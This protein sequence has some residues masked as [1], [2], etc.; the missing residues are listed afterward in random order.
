MAEAPEQP[1]S[2][3]QARRP[4]SLVPVG[5]KEAALD[6]PTFRATALH[7]SEHVD[8]VE[9]WLDAYVRS[10]TKLSHEVSTV[11]NLLNG[12]L[13][14]M[15]PPPNLS[16]AVIDHDY[17]LLAVKRYGEGAK[18]FWGSTI[19]G[20]RKLETNM[21]DPVRNFLQTDLRAFKETRRLLDQSQKQLDS[22]QSRYSAQAKTKEPS[23]LREDAFQLHEA[24]K[25]Y[26]KACMDFCVTTP[27]FRLALDKMLVKVSSDQW[28]DMR[29]A[30]ENANMALSRTS[31]DLDRIRGWS[32]EM[33]NGERTFKRE[34][35][36][37]RKQIEE[38][39]ESLVRPSR[40]LEDYATTSKGPS[41]SLSSAKPKAIQ[42]EKQGWL[43][44]RTVTGKPARTS[45]LR[46]WFFVKNGI[47]G[48]LV[49]G[50]RSGGV[51]ESDRI[52]VLLCSV[53]L[54][55]QEERRFC[56]EVKTKDTS[57][58][59]QAESQP[60]L[61]EWMAVFDVA[62]KKALEDPASTDSPSIGSSQPMDPAFAISPPSAPE[63]A[64]SA[65]DA[66]I[67]HT[68]DEHSGT[69]FDRST[70]LPIPGVEHNASRGSFDFTNQ[71]RSTTVDR[72]GESSREPTGRLMSKLDLHRKST[73]SSQSG[74]ES[75]GVISPKSPTTAVGGIA[76]LIAA[77]HSAMPVGPAVPMPVLENQV[78]QRSTSLNLRNLPP[79]S[80]APSTFAAP[81]TP[82]NL[83]ATA[84]AVNRERGIGVG[85]G[86]MT[87]GMPSGIMA[88]LWG[89]SNWGYMNRLERGEVKPVQD[90]RRSLFPPS[91]SLPA[92][93][94]PKTAGLNGNGSPQER[95]TTRD[96]SPSHRKTI[97]L[98]GDVADLQRNLIASQE[99]P[100]SYPL[101]LRAQDA[102]FRL[103]FPNVKRQEKVVTVFRATWNP[104]DQQEFP[105]RVYVTASDIYF[106]S[107][108]LGLVLITG[109]SLKSIS[110]VTAAPGRDCDFLF[111]HL[112]GNVD[113]MNY[114]RI[115]IKTFL[116]P[117]KLLQ[118]RLNFLVQNANAEEPL[119]LEEIIKNLIRLESDD[120]TRSPSLESW[121]DFSNNSMQRSS[122]MQQNG[123]QKTARDLRA[124]VLVD[125]AFYGVDT[126]GDHSKENRIKLPPQPVVYAPRDMKVCAVEKVF[127]ISPKAL[128]H[129]MFGDRSAVWQLLYHE[130]RAQRIKQGPWIQEEGTHMRRTF[131]YRIEY[132]DLFRARKEAGI[133]DH[134]MIDVLNDHLLYVVTDRKT[135]WHLP[136]AND[137]MLVSKVVITHVAK[138]KCK[139]AVYTKIDWSRLPRIGR[140]MIEQQ[141][142]ADLKLDAEDLADVISDQ[143]RKLGTQSRTKK[144]I[145]IFGYI[146][147]QKQMIE[148]GENSTNV[149][150][151]TRRTL[152]RR[153]I[154][155]LVLESVSS[156]IESMITSVLQWIGDFLR[157]T[158]KILSA[159]RVILIVLL[160]SLLTNLFFSWSGT[161]VWWME[162]NARSYMQKL[163]VGPDLVMSKAVHLD[164]LDLATSLNSTFFDGSSNACVRT[165]HDLT[166]PSN[167]SSAI[168]STHSTYTSRR[169]RR[170]RQH[171]GTYRY[172]LLVAMR[173][174]NS[175][176]QE[177]IQ[178]EWEEWTR[179]EN[180]RCARMR[181]LLK[182]K[183]D[184]KASVNREVSGTALG[185]VDR[186]RFNEYCRSCRAAV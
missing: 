108:H 159:N 7:F 28:R 101:Q 186:E 152:G 114:T 102:Q 86:D 65:A 38:Q 153:T 166:S 33:E 32:R 91:P 104:N 127:N 151:H 47:F 75:S 22:L 179:A 12:F 9:K 136:Y 44:L 85:R 125:R 76:S 148:F 115:T 157:W 113:Q 51:E 52:G 41:V 139:L 149:D 123:V 175:I 18:E 158:W 132:L 72:D 120:A 109:I 57:V 96:S 16:E 145:Q 112:N 49:Q 155:G 172:D 110:E 54:A 6:S 81:P 134:Q 62:K 80:L 70:T 121:E 11:E 5:L 42:S 61:L 30:R 46:R 118:R 45:W 116:E 34:L 40:E 138:S 107:N 105:G 20:L 183:E 87:G 180:R 68:T 147:Q 66:G 142:M 131:E 164:D 43:N 89:S 39:A 21:V 98:D 100:S 23:A 60:E 90:T 24:R 129:V 99:F 170:T 143:V 181:E 168:P 26:L 4:V 141:A 1:P 128:F 58:I 31:T 48:W 78:Q 95:Q 17:T 126:K 106:Y 84:V 124:T 74:F 88:N 77:S 173:V 3:V 150:S 130:R 94:P 29:S 10:T 160:A 165:F 73:A 8:A 27:Q 56:F 14:Q 37:A 79:S 119:D 122:S 185:N 71:R 167:P 146:G 182:S 15:V 50:S 19:A 67:L 144:A 174:V 156:F 178:A 63:F 64:A 53:R 162:R 83:S 93:S 117:L 97:S 92:S 25:A 103:L 69:S 35:L 154:T 55:A 161:S 36:I 111:L 13:S 137:Y 140:R 133:V 171:L 177:M 169:L 2:V 135:P 82:T 176:E 59:L 163:G 184:N